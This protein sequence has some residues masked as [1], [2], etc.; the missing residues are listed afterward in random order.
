MHLRQL[1]RRATRAR[2]SARRA[3]RGKRRP[4]HRGRLRIP[5]PGRAALSLQPLPR[6]AATTPGL[7]KTQR[8]SQTR[9]R[10]KA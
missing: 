9:L 10:G 6:M 4:Q 1:P 8:R 5:R 2:K 3:T 7:G